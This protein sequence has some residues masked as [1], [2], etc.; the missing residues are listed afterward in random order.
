MLIGAVITGVVTSLIGNPIPLFLTPQFSLVPNEVISKLGCYS[1]SDKQYTYTCSNN[2][3]HF[4]LFNE[5]ITLKN[6][7]FKQ[8]KNVHA[9][10]NSVN[11]SRIVSSD[12]PET[13]IDDQSMNK[14]HKINFDRMS[15]GIPCDIEFQSNTNPVV[16]S[17]TISG[18]DSPG[19]HWVAGEEFQRQIWSI[20][21]EFVIVMILT[22]SF[23]IFF[24][25]QFV[26]FYKQYVANIQLGIPTKIK[27]Y[28]ADV[29]IEEVISNAN[30]ENIVEAHVIQ[31]R[32]NWINEIGKAS[33]SK[34]EYRKNIDGTTDILMHF[35]K[36]DATITITGVTVQS[37]DKLYKAARARVTSTNIDVM[38]KILFAGKHP[39]YAFNWEFYNEFNVDAAVTR[40]RQKT[41]KNPIS[42]SSLAGTDSVP[43]VTDAD[44]ALINTEEFAV[45]IHLS[46][47]TKDTGGK[48]GVIF[49]PIIP[50]RGIF[51]IKSIS[52]SSISSMI[53]GR[54]SVDEI[55]KKVRKAS[56]LPNKIT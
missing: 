30:E 24:I 20:F 25:Y 7:G 53:Y 44:Y 45:R 50:N 38:E 32:G 54:I 23:M 12:C 51:Q 47:G 4:W 21:I 1:S 3:T 33:A 40:I 28:S 31:T 10:V 34:S 2:Q 13:I 11:D 35:P 52:V 8:A 5:K 22:V 14:I 48:I 17:A 6:T 49:D 46:K 56:M 29:M 26:R 37:R 18:D 36:G 39:F 55:L 41:G 9:L 19:F 42:S 43:V 27:S 16:N 15:N